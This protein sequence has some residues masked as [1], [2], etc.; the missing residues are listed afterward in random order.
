[1]CLSFPPPPYNLS[2]PFIDNLLRAWIRGKLSLRST[3]LLPCW[4]MYNWSSAAYIYMRLSWLFLWPTFH[5]KKSDPAILCRQQTFLSR[6][7]AAIVPYR[8]VDRDN[9]LLRWYQL[10]CIGAVQPQTVPHIVIACLSMDVCALVTSSSSWSPPH[11]SGLA[12][13]APLTRSRF[14]RTCSW[15]LTPQK[16]VQHHPPVTHTGLIRNER[17]KVK[18]FLQDDRVWA[19]ATYTYRY[20]IYMRLGGFILDPHRDRH[21]YIGI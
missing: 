21:I 9:I 16:S 8:H 15:L 12:H 10:P 11:K 13:T 17:R 3:H 18:K 5:R 1:M 4:L 2:S 20:I 6:P 14:I 7:R 19:I